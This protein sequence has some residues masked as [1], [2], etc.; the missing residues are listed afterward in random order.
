MLAGVIAAHVAA[1]SEEASPY[2]AGTAVVV[3]VVVVVVAQE[4]MVGGCCFDKKRPDAPAF[5]SVGS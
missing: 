4:E 5:Q 3:V 1:C 2:E